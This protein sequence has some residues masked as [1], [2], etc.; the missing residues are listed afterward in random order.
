[1]NSYR[2]YPYIKVVS[3]PASF[4]RVLSKTHKKGLID[5]GLLNNLQWISQV[6]LLLSFNVQLIWT[7]SLVLLCGHWPFQHRFHINKLEFWDALPLHCGQV[8]VFVGFLL[9]SYFILFIKALQHKCWRSVGHQV[10][11]TI[12]LLL[13]RTEEKRIWWAGQRSWTGFFYSSCFG[14]TGGME[15]E[16]LIFYHR[17]ADWLSR[18][19]QGLIAI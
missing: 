10:L 6:V 4:L 7:V 14:T 5:K 11:Y 12:C 19:G 9:Q 1:M 3:S 18:Q 8:I 2:L 16:A 17:L 13:P 15:K